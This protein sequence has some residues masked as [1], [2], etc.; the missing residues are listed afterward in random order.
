[1]YGKGRE[2]E[3][4]KR[5]QRNSDFAAANTRRKEHSI[6]CGGSF[7]LLTKAASDASANGEGFDVLHLMVSRRVREQQ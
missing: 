4:S 6:E 7:A 2:I 1:M 3:I 5:C